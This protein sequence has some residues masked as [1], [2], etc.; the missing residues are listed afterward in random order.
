MAT[1]KVSK[2]D[3]VTAEGVKVV[4]NSMLRQAHPDDWRTVILTGRVIGKGLGRKTKVLWT[5]GNNQVESDVGARVLTVVQQAGGSNSAIPAPVQPDDTDDESVQD[6]NDDMSISG[7]EEMVFLDEE[8]QDNDDAPPDAGLQPG[9][10]VW[11]PEPDGIE[12]C[13]RECSGNGSEYMPRLKWPRNNTGLDLERT[14]IDYWLFMFPTMLDDIVRWTN[15]ALPA[16]AAATTKYEI[17]KFFGIQYAMT[18]FPSRQ[19]RDYWS[20]VDSDLLP[21]PAFGQRFGMSRDRFELLVRCTTFHDPQEDTA[22]PLDPWRQVRTFIDK[23]NANR[24]ENV[25]PGWVLVVDEST[26]KWRSLGDW[27]DLGMPHVTKIPRKPEPVGLELKDMCD[28]ESGIML[29]L[30]IMEGKE[31][32]DRKAFTGGGNKAGTAHCLRCT[33]P[34]HGSGRVL[35]GDS[36]FASVQSCIQLRKHGI[37]FVGLVKGSSLLYPKRHL[38]TMPMAERGDTATFTA[39]KD[40]VTMIAHVWNDPGKPKK[41]RKAL[42]S[43][44]GTTLEADPVERPR[45]R[46]RE[47]GT[48]EDYIKTVKRTKLVKTYFK[49]AGAID[50][51]NRVRMDGVRMERTLEFKRWW[52][53][54]VS[55]V[56]GIIATDAFYAMRMGD[57]DLQLDAFMERLASEMIWNTFDGAPFRD[58]APQTRSSDEQQESNLIGS[59]LMSAADALRQAIQVTDMSQA[60]CKHKI[61]QLRDLEKYQGKTKVQLTCAVCRAVSA[62]LYCTNC[63]GGA[64][65]K[66]LCLC[67]P[68]TK[69]QCLSIHCAT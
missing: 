16:R 14:P 50:R 11:M 6:P 22:I 38:Q 54:V 44:F 40:R 28:G 1:G 69:K 4:Q 21:A 61:G 27:Y 49:Y 19:R 13:A 26:S 20:I 58:G 17:V 25:V 45:K 10:L 9:G 65:N 29:Y 46:R 67:G 57:P 60:T 62:T 2:D 43:T 3:I 23:F 42:I 56:L 18:L 53:R 12:L 55:S 5:L 31:I 24:A 63:S 52:C 68:G 64:H 41:P 32:M 59:A 35:V 37:Y 39:T 51:H 8:P 15:L 47:D 48:W 66:L 34:W 7:D 33:Q 36:A 30:E